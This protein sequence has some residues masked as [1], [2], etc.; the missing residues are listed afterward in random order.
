LCI[1]VVI[2]PTNLT[3]SD[4]PHHHLNFP[5]NSPADWSAYLFKVS[6]FLAFG[7]EE[8]P[9]K[10]KKSTQ[11]ISLAIT[12]F[13]AAVWRT[14]TNDFLTMGPED[15]PTISGAANLIAKVAAS[16][17]IRTLHPYPKGFGSAGTRSE[18]QAAA[19]LAYVQRKLSK[20]PDGV[21]VA[22]TDGASRG[23]PGPS[24]AGC[25]CFIKGRKSLP[26]EAYVGLGHS[27]NNTSELWAIGLAF[28]L[29]AKLSVSPLK[30]LHIFSDSTYTINCLQG[31]SIS[32]TNGQLV[33]ALLRSRDD[34]IQDKHFS[35]LNLDWSPGH[36]GLQENEQADFLA[37]L[38]A[39]RTAAGRAIGPLL[40]LAQHGNF[41]GLCP[42]AS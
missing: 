42:P 26:L 10:A 13:N 16:S 4:L 21:I 24:G 27:T 11:N 15:R 1:G 8:L 41:L 20:I 36:C 28:Q 5:H 37:N 19:A 3:Y 34:H 33:T 9:R 32:S 18:K 31:S 2:D 6:S 7:T 29:A 35:V 23:N 30:P 14:R 40:S 12:N 38:G 22:F 17:W 39:D 25:L